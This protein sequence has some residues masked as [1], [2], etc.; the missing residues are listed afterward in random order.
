MTY[1]LARSPLIVRTGERRGHLVQ[2]FFVVRAQLTWSKIDID[3][4]NLAGEWKRRFVRV[5]CRR[6]GIRPDTERVNAE[7]SGDGILDTCA[8]NH[9]AVYRDRGRASL[10]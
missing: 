8:A 6:A 1:A 9:F 2:F 3:A 5:S 4:F 10:A 7:P